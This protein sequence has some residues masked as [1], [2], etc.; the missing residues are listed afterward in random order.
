VQR[1]CRV[2]RPKER[3]VDLQRTDGLADD[4][5]RAEKCYLCEDLVVPLGFEGQGRYEPA[6][7]PS[8]QLAKS[9]F[10]LGYLGLTIS[11]TV[12][13]AAAAIR[14]GLAAA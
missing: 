3:S 11:G 2:C 9:A 5:V 1:D 12:A 7:R 4:L 6:T 8:R 10:Q 13:L 14:L